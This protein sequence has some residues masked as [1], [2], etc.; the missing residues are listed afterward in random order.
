MTFWIAAAVAIGAFVR[1][2]RRG[3]SVERWEQQR[4]A[5]ARRSYE[6]RDA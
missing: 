6:N 4:R 3:R 5:S 1:G 2:T